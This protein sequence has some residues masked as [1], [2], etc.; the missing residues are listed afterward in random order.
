MLDQR[1]PLKWYL[2]GVGE[3]GFYRELHPFLKKWSVSCGSSKITIGRFYI[4]IDSNLK[5]RGMRADNVYRLIDGVSYSH[6][7]SNTLMS[8]GIDTA[9]G[10][11][12]AMQKEATHCREQVETLNSEYRELRKE[13]EKSREE[14]QL[15]RKNLRDIT[16]E[17]LKLRK[18]C[19]VAERKAGKK[20]AN[21]DTLKYEYALL[22]DAYADNAE[23][24]QALQNELSSVPDSSACNDSG[25]FTFITK[26]GRR[27]SPAV[28][29]LYYSLLSAQVPSSRI[30]EI[31][32]T[33]IRC[34]SPSIDV[35][36]LRL[37]HRTCADY[38]R[39]DELKS[40]SNAHKATVLCSHASE[41]Q[42]F[43]LN[44]DGTTKFQRKIGGTAI[45]NMVISVNELPDGTASSAIDDVSRELQK[46]R[47]TAHALGI[48]NADSINW[49]LVAVSSSDSVASQKRFNR[50]IEDYRERD[51]ENFG[52]ATVETIDLIESF[53]SMHLGINLRKA[54]LSEIC[55][56]DTDEDSSSRKY[57][58]VNVI[59]HEFCKVFGKSGTPEYGCGVQAFPDFLA[60]MLNDS[61]LSEE[62]ELHEYYCLCTEVSLHRQV[63][64]RY[65]VSAANAVKIV[66][67]REAAIN[68]L[69]YTG[70][71]TGNNLFETDLYMKLLDCN[72]IARLRADSLM[73]F[74]VY[75]DLVMLF[76]VE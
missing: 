43:V 9:V 11:I 35:E 14:L 71:D 69:N 37:P 26:C 24:I 51:E 30:A 56:E 13:F 39:K 33:V 40:V 19:D 8:Y 31:I 20:S 46:L 49:T 73:Y 17:N 4:A 52:P 64:S 34:F 74:H 12:R 62:L 58:P 45:N 75:A 29:K 68:F 54:F 63:G 28:R 18:N 72:E 55:S 50:L 38:M 42:S 23:T 3:V 48:P 70:K 21:L 57:N 15:A 47:R 27:Y 16:N 22:E 59:I 60:I 61:S 66:F 5:L 10:E 1:E 2:K 65:F 67:L 6:C 36:Q 76:K 32:K 44:T 53:C 41:N 7:P 25:D